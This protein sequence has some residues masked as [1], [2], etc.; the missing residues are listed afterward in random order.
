[1]SNHGQK[2]FR[3]LLSLASFR[4]LLSLA[5]KGNREAQWQLQ[6]RKQSSLI[7]WAQRLIPF[8]DR[9]R[10]SPDDVVQIVHVQAHAGFPGFDGEDE[11]TYRNW[12]ITILRRVIGGMKRD[13][14]RQ[15]R[16]FRREV[17][18]QNGSNAGS[19]LVDPSQR[20]GRSSEPEGSEFL[21]AALDLLDETERRR[22]LLFHQEGFNYAEIA[23]QEDVTETALRTQVMRT[24]A[25]LREIIGLFQRMHEQNILPLQRRAIWL[26]CFRGRTPWKIALE[27][28]VPEACIRD[29]IDDAKARGLLGKGA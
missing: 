12:L 2:S 23:R 22:F 17:P 16:D 15:I 24:R 1:M 10:T 4:S 5:H 29:W 19:W 28:N 26:W 11:V 13:S 14:R 25:K 7:R 9:A 27:L 21:D 8:R 3:S 18:L 20:S 6:A